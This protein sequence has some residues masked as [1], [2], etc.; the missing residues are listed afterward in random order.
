MTDT[1]YSSGM[2]K[3]GTLHRR[4][5]VVLCRVRT[6]GS[7]MPVSARGV[8]NENEPTQMKMGQLPKAIDPFANLVAGTGFEPVTFGL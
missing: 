1:P 4:H 6:H 5:A 2:D 7:S 3:A 8:S